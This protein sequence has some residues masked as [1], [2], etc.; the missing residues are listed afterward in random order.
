MSTLITKGNE[1]K[2]VTSATE[3]NGNIAEKKNLV[4]SENKDF[5][6]KSAQIAKIL[7]PVSAE[8]RIKNADNFQKVA[9]KHKFLSL[10][11]DELNSFMIGRDGLREKIVIM[12]DNEQTFEISNTFVIEEVLNLCSDKLEKL[13]E[14]SKTEILTFTV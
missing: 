2:T 3:K 7:Q 9:E 4:K 8:Q 12:N 10:K 14:E 1:A 5:A 13:I 6:E 11:I